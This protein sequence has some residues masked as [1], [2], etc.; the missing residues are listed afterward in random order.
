MKHKSDSEV[1]PMP[2]MDKIGKTVKNKKKKNNTDT[3]SDIDDLPEDLAN[4]LLDDSVF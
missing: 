4:M 3:C 1:P 2:I